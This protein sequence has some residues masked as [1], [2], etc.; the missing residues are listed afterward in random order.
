MHSFSED[1]DPLLIYCNSIIDSINDALSKPSEDMSVEC[2][3]IALKFNKVDLLTRWIAQRKITFSYQAAQLIEDYARLKAKN[4][5]SA[6]ELA[7]FIY[8]DIKAPLEATICMAKLGR[9]SSM[10]DFIK[11]QKS[12][13]SN[14]EIYF[15]ILKECPSVELATEIMDVS[16]SFKHLN[17]GIY[18]LNQIILFQKISENLKIPVDKIVAILLD[19]DQPENG[20]KF[21]KIQIQKSSICNI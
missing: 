3:R 17:F 8:T 19:S 14:N 1:T 7:L 21:L 10:I 12:L 18:F 20:L 16:V 11:S 5:K 13:S 4:S 6:F 2:L 15:H 9:L